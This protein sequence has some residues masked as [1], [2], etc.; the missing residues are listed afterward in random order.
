VFSVYLYRDTSPRI[1][2]GEDFTPSR[3]QCLNKIVQDDIGQMF[4]KDAFGSEAPKI[5]F[6]AF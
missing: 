4:M 1:E 3:F 5:E 6:E 2:F